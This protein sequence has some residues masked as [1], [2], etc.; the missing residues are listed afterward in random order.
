MRMREGIGKAKF[1]KVKEGELWLL[2]KKL[3]ILFGKGTHQEILQKLRTEM[4]ENYKCFQ[5]L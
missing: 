1:G 5:F 4:C 2:G 3:V